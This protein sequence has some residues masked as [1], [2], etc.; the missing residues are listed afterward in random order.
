MQARKRFAIGLVLLAAMTFSFVE[1]AAASL[2]APMSDTSA[3]GD[4]Q[5]MP[6]MAE[7]PADQ[8]A[9]GDHGPDDAD[10]PAGDCPYAPAGAGQSCAS[11]SLPASGFD[12]L[13]SPFE[14]VAELTRTEIEPHLVLSSVLFHPP[15]S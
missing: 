9:A 14:V 15:K 4:M 8:D 1:T 11:A 12:L 2:C 10:R 6:G 7:L 5:D 3:T 13:V